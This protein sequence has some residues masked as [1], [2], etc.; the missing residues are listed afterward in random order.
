MILRR[1]VGAVVVS[2]A[3]SP[4]RLLPPLLDPTR[5]DAAAARPGASCVAHGRVVD[6]RPRCTTNLWVR[7]RLG[8]RR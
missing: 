7:R 6:R 8:W 3:L 2:S 5:R 4:S 1:A